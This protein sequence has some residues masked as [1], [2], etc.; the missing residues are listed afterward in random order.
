MPS[1]R[2]TSESHWLGER[3]LPRMSTEKSAV[4]MILLWYVTCR[5][6]RV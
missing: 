6:A 3:R 1:A 4:Q 5:G 2:T